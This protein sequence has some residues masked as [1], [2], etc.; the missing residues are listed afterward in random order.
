[1]KREWL[2]IRN[3]SPNICKQL[4]KSESQLRLKGK[5][6]FGEA[7]IQCQPFNSSHG[8]KRLGETFYIASTYPQMRRW[9]R[10]LVLESQGSSLQDFQSPKEN[11]QRYQ[12][13]F[14]VSQN[15]YLN[16]YIF[17]DPVLLSLWSID[18]LKD[19]PETV[20]TGSSERL[21]AVFTTMF[22][23]FAHPTPS[24]FPLTS[25]RYWVM[26]LEVQSHSLPVFLFLKS[27]VVHQPS[28]KF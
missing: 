13:L 9:T 26:E 15:Y 6:L 18:T 20:S 5:K 14:L 4:N 10:R 8:S 1:M 3:C 28:S 12:L 21:S 22:H 2:A 17:A 7:T 16:H 24:R 25:S 11:E 23:L 27:Q 19:K